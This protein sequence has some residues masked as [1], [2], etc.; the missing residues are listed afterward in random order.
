MDYA[1]KVSVLGVGASGAVNR[2]RVQ[3]DIEE[4]GHPFSHC[5]AKP[6]AFWQR[7]CEHHQ[8]THIVDFCPGSGALAIAA[9][10][11]V[12]YEG[13]AGNDAHCHWLDATL[14]RCIMYMAGQD[15]RVTKNLGGDDSFAAKVEKYLSGTMMEARRMLE[16]RRERK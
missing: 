3:K 1:T 11:A 12:E 13:I 4:N 10:G 6:I 9:S 15:K 7:I 2:P 14:D 16:P 5:E 8:V